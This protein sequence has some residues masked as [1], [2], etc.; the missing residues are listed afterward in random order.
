MTI[1]LG[2]K[3]LMMP[4]GTTEL[5]YRVSLRTARLVAAPGDRQSAYKFLR[6]SY[7]ERSQFVHGA[8]AAVDP[9]TVSATE[10]YLRQVLLNCVRNRKVPSAQDLDSSLLGTS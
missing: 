1:G 5:M 2:W 3:S 4:D 6:H 10:D 9:Q 8:K 7:G